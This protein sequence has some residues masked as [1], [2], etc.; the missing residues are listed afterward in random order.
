M[1]G[2]YLKGTK[3]CS[4]KTTTCLSPAEMPLHQYMQHRQQ[5]QATRRSLEPPENYDLVDITESSWEKSDAGSTAIKGCRHSE[6]TE[7]RV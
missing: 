7:M 2:K 4:S 1:P 6:E 3:G 5:A